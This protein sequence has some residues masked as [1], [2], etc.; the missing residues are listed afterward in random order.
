MKILRTFL[1]AAVLTLA[2]TATLAEKPETRTFE[3]DGVTYNYTSTE[4]GGKTILRGTAK[5]GAPFR[6]VVTKTKVRGTV[7]SKYVTFAR[8]KSKTSDT[9]FIAT[10]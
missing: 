7:G 2:S 10:R 3:R 6:L 8:P 9:V 5:G 4:I 1:T